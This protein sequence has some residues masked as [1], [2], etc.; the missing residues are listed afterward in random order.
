MSDAQLMTLHVVWSP[1]PLLAVGLCEF[2]IER[3]MDSIQQSV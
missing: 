2:A 3:L 1:C